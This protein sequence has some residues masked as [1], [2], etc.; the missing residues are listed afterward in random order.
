MTQPVNPPGGIH[1]VL[2]DAGGVLLD[3]DFAYLRRLLESR[4]H[5]VESSD[6]ARAEGL[7]RL[8]IDRR[9]RDGGRASEAWRD[10]FRVLLSAVHSPLD[11]REEI[12]DVL[13]DA[14]E[15][16]GLWTVPAPGAIPAM[17]E[18]KRRGYR[19]GVVSN[20]E[21]RVE[22]DLNAAGYD[23][24]FETIVDSSI[25]GFEKPDPAIFRIALERLGV[26]A[27]GTV[28]LGDVPAVDVAGARAAGIA[29]VLLDRFDLYP[30]AD[31]PC[32][33]SI[34]DLPPWLESRGDLRQNVTA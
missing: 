10:Y 1:T 8:E 11:S 31:A 20:A 22:R 13:R 26:V 28:F 9:V 6:L 3:L 17:R 23:G 21:G 16:F 14:H 19:L 12:I 25:V 18:L 27:Q 30:A 33:R 15:R 2:L 32:L 5:P 29:A 7:A 34:G 24:L 4:D